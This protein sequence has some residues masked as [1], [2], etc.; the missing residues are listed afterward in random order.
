MPAK[1]AFLATASA[2]RPRSSGSRLAQ[3]MSD[4]AEDANVRHFRQCETLCD[5]IADALRRA[6]AAM[7]LEHAL[8]ALR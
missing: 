7:R 8:R 5:D 1:A 4:G 3:A 6:D 2:E